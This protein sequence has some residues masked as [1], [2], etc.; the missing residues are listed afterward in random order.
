MLGKYGDKK[1]EGISLNDS[2]NSLQSLQT[3]FKHQMEVQFQM[4]SMEEQ[5]FYLIFCE[6]MID[7]QSLQQFVF[8]AIQNEELQQLSLQPVQSKKEAS[9]LIFK[10]SLLIF[11]YEKNKLYACD[12]ANRPNRQPEPTA[13]EAVVKGPRDNFIEDLMTNIA[14][15]RKRLPT[16]ALYSEK[17]T[18][19]NDSKTDIA[20]LYMPNVV[21]KKA[22]QEVRVRLQTLNVEMILSGDHLM[23]LLNERTLLIPRYEYTGRPDFTAQAIQEG[24]LVLLMDGAPYAMITPVNLLMLTKAGD[25]NEYSP[26]Y[27]SFGRLLRFFS[28]LVGI[29]LPAFWLALTTFHQNQLP[30]QLLATVVQANTGLPF[31]SALEMIV[32]ILM[33]ELFR[34]AG[35][36]LPT[37]VGGT[38]SVVGGLI[39]GDAAIRAGVTSPAM[40]VVIAIS[41]IATF[42]LVNQ[43]LLAAVSILRIIFVLVTSFFGLFGFFIVLYFMLLHLANIRIFGMPYLHGIATLKWRTIK[44]TFI[45]PKKGDDDE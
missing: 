23:E 15:V 13:L 24:R 32:M 4:I 41:T 5:T 17:I 7:K 12:I 2:N 37:V 45:Q 28:I 3:L 14:L 22:L 43:S 19:G 26:I 44:A 16:T 31:P 9:Q 25:D 34:E 10:G 40:I 6:G 11:F 35:A 20:L 38:F 8:P 29:L 39:I 30:F 36:R 18:A 21:Y 1:K 33:F 27:T 42:T